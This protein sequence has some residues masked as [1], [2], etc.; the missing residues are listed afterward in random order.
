MESTGKDGFTWPSVLSTLP[1]SRS[2]LTP[3]DSNRISMAAV[4]KSTDLHRQRVQR[5]E[6]PWCSGAVERTR[7]Q[8]SEEGHLALALLCTRCLT[9]PLPRALTL[10]LLKGLR[11]SPL[12]FLY[13]GSLYQLIT[14]KSHASWH[15]HFIKY[16]ILYVTGFYLLMY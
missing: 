4:E 7:S 1:L 11:V 5:S 9:W 10:H 12:C 15:E 8:S 16:F 13:I 14:N 6:N 3:L 2:Q